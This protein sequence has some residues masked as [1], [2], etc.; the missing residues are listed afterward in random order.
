MVRAIA[1][2]LDRRNVVA[3]LLADRHDLVV[4]TGLGSP[5]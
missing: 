4:V 2:T 5:S 1:G 3:R